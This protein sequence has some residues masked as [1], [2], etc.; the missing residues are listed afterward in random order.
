M[1]A[2]LVIVAAL[3]IRSVDQEQYASTCMEV[4]FRLTRIFGRT[5]TWHGQC[6][7]VVMTSGDGFGFAFS[8]MPKGGQCVQCAVSLGAPSILKIF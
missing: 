2:T 1:I 7:F 8:P 5:V 6:E 4:F 3:L